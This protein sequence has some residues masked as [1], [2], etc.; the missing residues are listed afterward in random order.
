MPPKISEL[1]EGIRR[2]EQELEAEL[3]KKR[4]ELRFS[5][6]NRKIRFEQEVLLQHKKLKIGLASYLLHVPLRH[7]VSVPFIYSVFFILLLLDLA[8]TLYQGIC[9]PLYG[10]P[11]VKRRDFMIYDHKHLAYLNGIEKINCLYCSYASGLASYTKEI[12][13]RTEQYWC[14]IKHAQRINQ[15]HS[16]YSRFI[17]FG[18]GEGYRRE[19]ENIRCDFSSGEEK[20]EEGK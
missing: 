11:K 13:A 19:L 6:E 15:A 9:F 5:I 12:V 1:V 3:A 20:K 17:D 10:I 18:D 4:T 14:P 8:V 16:R 2:L 7:L